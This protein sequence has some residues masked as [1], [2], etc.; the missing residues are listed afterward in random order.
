MV[1]ALVSLWPYL[2]VWLVFINAASLTAFG[3]DKRQARR[4]GGRVPERTLLMM[5]L[6]GGWPGA[7]LGQ[8]RFRHKTRK[9]PFARRLNAVPLGWAAGAAAL[10]VSA[11][12]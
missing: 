3:L 1:E 12:I 5:A 9:Q 11:R 2:L 8:R 10:A 4:G 7:K 6:A